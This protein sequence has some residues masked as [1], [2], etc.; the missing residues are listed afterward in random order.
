MKVS[1]AIRRYDF[2]TFTDS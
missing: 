1:R 2:E